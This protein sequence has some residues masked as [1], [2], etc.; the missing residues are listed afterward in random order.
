MTLAGRTIVVTRPRE[1]AARLLQ[2]LRAAGCHAVD[3]PVIEIVPLEDIAPLAA[4]A[5]R[6]PEYDV[7]FFVSPNAVRHAL[8]ALPRQTWPSQI[9][10]A[11]VGPSSA[12]TLLHAGF[13]DVIVPTEHFDSEGVLALPAFAEH[14]IRGRRVL[15]L[16]GDGGRELLADTLR[17]RGATVDTVACY[18]RRRAH[19]DPAPLN[20]LHAHGKLD[21]IVF[22]SSESV[23]YFAELLGD[24][25]R[26]ILSATVLF[27]PHPRIGEALTV[28]G[29]QQVILTG[30]GDEGILTALYGHFG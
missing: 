1:Q 24:A 11:T 26:P 3:F 27:A 6:L 8:D 16:R 10:I 4:L 7:A 15:I 19:L 13:D 18:H 17:A 28:H 5:A 2:D 14:A 29:A 20:A 21:A 30:P 22:T 23:R 9:T 25:T 12:Q